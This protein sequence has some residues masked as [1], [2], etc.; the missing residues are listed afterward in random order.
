M[1]MEAGWIV[2]KKEQGRKVSGGV[3]HKQKEEEERG[4]FW[5]D[6]EMYFLLFTLE[7]NYMNN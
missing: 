5:L 4:R 3:T 1:S 2:Q 7:G 6:S